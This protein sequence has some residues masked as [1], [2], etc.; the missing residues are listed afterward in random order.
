MLEL[1]EETNQGKKKPSKERIKIVRQAKLC[2]NCLAFGHMAKGCLEVKLCTV[3]GCERTHHT[4]LH[5]LKGDPN[6]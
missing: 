3:D 4:L 5:A 6:G 1:Q 2:D